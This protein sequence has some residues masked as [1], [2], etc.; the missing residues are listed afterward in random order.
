M[1]LD[2]R[3]RALRA[4]V[5]TAGLGSTPALAQHTYIGAAADNLWCTPGNWNPTSV[6][7]G[8]AVI[9]G[10]I[11]QR[12]RMAG[13]CT[14]TFQSLTAIG[15]V[16]FNGDVRY[17]GA[18]IAA[19]IIMRSGNFTIGPTVAGGATLSLTD[20]AE[21]ASGI[22]ARQAITV[23]AAG[24]LRIPQG[25]GRVLLRASLRN[26]GTVTQSGSVNIIGDS[27]QGITNNGLWTLAA[28]GSLIRTVSITDTAEFTNFG[29]LATNFVNTSPAAISLPVNNFGEIRVAVGNLDLSTTSHTGAQSLLSVSPGR[30]L[31]LAGAATID[32][33]AQASGDGTVA[34]TSGQVTVTAGEFLTA[35]DQS[36]SFGGGFLL[37]TTDGLGFGDGATLRN[38]GTF[39]WQRGPILSSLE[40]SVPI[41]NDGNFV[42]RAAGGLLNRAS[43]NNCGVLTIDLPGSLVNLR[44]TSIRSG[45][46]STI[47]L[48]AG[49]IAHDAASAPGR[50]ATI[51]LSGTLIKL[52]ATPAGTSALLDAGMGSRID[53]QEG[54]FQIFPAPGNFIHALIDAA[55]EVRS[56]AI[57]RLSGR[58][59]ARRTQ[60]SGLG[61]FRVAAGG[62]IFTDFN[63]TVTAS[64]L[65]SSDGLHIQSGQILGEG[66]VQN[67]GTMVL[68]GSTLGDPGPGLFPLEIRNTGFLHARDSTQLIR[69]AHVL[70]F[71]EMA[72]DA[73]ITLA[74]GGL[75]VNHQTCSIGEAVTINAQPAPPGEPVGTLINEI[76][77]VLTKRELDPATIS[78]PFSNTGTVRVQQGR[79][80]IVG[81][82]VELITNG[83]GLWELNGGTWTVQP[84]ASLSFGNRLFSILSGNAQVVVN[85]TFD[86]FEPT[87]LRDQSVTEIGTLL[88]PSEDMIVSDN[89]RITLNAG[90]EIGNA[91]AC[92]V[93]DCT[94]ITLDGTTW[95][96]G[97]GLVDRLCILNGQATISPGSSPGT[98]AFRSLRMQGGVLEI[99]L[100][101]PLP[102]TQHD[103]IIVQNAATLG[104]TLAVRVLPGFSPQSGETFDI[105]TA[106]SIAG[107]FARI[108]AEG[109][110]SDQRA[111]V[112][113]LSDR[114]RL[115][116]TETACDYDYNKDENVDLLDAQQMAQVFVGL[117]TPES[118]WLD[119]DLNGD[120][121]AD[122]TD[123][124]ILAIFVVSGTCGL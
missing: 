27:N 114:V 11:T 36:G 13:N 99:E 20:S 118:N 91:P 121:N 12:V 65:G 39:T 87:R 78:A 116:I 41:V 73:P 100:G 10:T 21:W 71:A 72:V 83:Q 24:H 85:G 26:E 53:V 115:S 9:P 22:L 110:R 89:A 43:I 23:E 105:L 63:T 75:I 40:F 54:E 123:A 94:R 112:A 66:T 18:V 28:S 108:E 2:A 97:N 46:G 96:T 6:P 33:G 101:G 47:R 67:T 90:G 56:G 59:S 17:S 88:D 117:V 60:I 82:I 31:T 3:Q 124:Q 7:G 52:T 103:Q 42:V 77:G 74:P 106:S 19:D 86:D 122:L 35:L 81:P 5:L 49:T 95:L 64:M 29:V 92:P 111:T 57:L 58:L 34:A 93:G 55:V 14:P 104:G 68:S 107:N 61:V 50:P 32:G 119:G 62:V 30:R 15:P 102:G 51:H 109:L 113:V 25:G 8:A 79:L 44:D 45:A 4:L 98:L 16:D 76:T 70:N 80:Q 69:L 120:E 37:N 84:E 48:R 1:T 38:A